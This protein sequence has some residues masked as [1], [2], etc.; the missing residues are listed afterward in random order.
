MYKISLKPV[1]EFTRSRKHPLPF[2]H[3]LTSTYFDQ[4]RIDFFLKQNMEILA[5]GFRE[6]SRL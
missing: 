1:E 3:L 2:L 6:D 5:S 4:P